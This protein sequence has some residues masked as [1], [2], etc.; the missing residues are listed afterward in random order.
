MG[1]TN[2]CNELDSHIKSIQLQW[3]FQIGYVALFGTVFAFIRQRL[4]LPI[5]SFGGIKFLF[6]KAM[7]IGNAFT[8]ISATYFVENTYH[9]CY[10]ESSTT[11]DEQPFLFIWLA[12][13]IAVLIILLCVVYCELQ[14]EKHNR[15]PHCI[16]I[17]YTDHQCS[18]CDACNNCISHS[19]LATKSEILREWNCARRMYSLLLTYIIFGLSVFFVPFYRIVQQN[20][21][22]INTLCICTTETQYLLSIGGS[23]LSFVATPIIALLILTW[24]TWI[25]CKYCCKCNCCTTCCVGC[26]RLVAYLAAVVFPSVFVLVKIYEYSQHE[27]FE[28]TVSNIYIVLYVIV[29]VIGVGIG[30]CVYCGMCHTK[31]KSV[32][33]GIV[34]GKLR[35]RLS[36]EIAFRNGVKDGNKSNSDEMELKTMPATRKGSRVELVTRY[37]NTRSRISV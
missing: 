24:I 26:Y 9:S 36:E 13:N 25:C 33:T 19:K 37:E 6:F 27:I 11:P 7:G 16:L 3:S 31:N 1:S 15:I 17:P 2:S 10:F 22:A 34:E 30:T 29:A 35:R 28:W 12:F 8:A 18:C 5:K 23:I 4:L 20:T 14:M 21:E 32:D